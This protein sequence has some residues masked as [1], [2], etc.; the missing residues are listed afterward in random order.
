MPAEDDLR[1]LAKIVAFMREVNILLVLMHLYWF[2]Y[3]F[4]LELGWT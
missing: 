4:F 1:V 2:C 3:D